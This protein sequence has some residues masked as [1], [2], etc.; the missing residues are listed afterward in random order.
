MNIEQ[1]KKDVENGVLISKS[2][3]AELI[4]AYEGYQNA[5][6]AIQ[7]QLLTD[8]A[9]LDWLDSEDFV[10]LNCYIAVYDDRGQPLEPERK[11]YVIER[12]SDGMSVEGATA[13]E[14]IDVARGAG[15]TGEVA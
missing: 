14:A 6:P 11:F 2:T 9:R 15:Q 10:A 12:E 1:L 4:A 7:A 13:R 8:A 3:W 5:A